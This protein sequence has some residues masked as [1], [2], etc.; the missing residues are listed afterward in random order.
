MA[1]RT[2]ETTE[3][4]P[5]CANGLLA[6]HWVAN[7]EGQ[8]GQ[9][10][11]VWMNTDGDV[12]G[13]MWGDYLNGQFRGEFI[14]R[15]GTITGTIGGTY[16]NGTFHGVWTS[17][18]SDLSGAMRGQYLST[19]AGEG[20][21]RGQWK[22]DCN[23]GGVDPV[24][25]PLPVPPHIICKKVTITTEVITGSD[26]VALDFSNAKTKTKVIVVCKKVAGPCTLVRLVME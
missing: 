20:V 21:F 10:R 14:A 18:D 8:G 22:I 11:G 25:M 4:A 5:G 24:P 15:G 13:Y 23:N 3:L 17:V 2:S 1:R 16:A 7:D 19:G 26:A 6:G 9:F 12:L